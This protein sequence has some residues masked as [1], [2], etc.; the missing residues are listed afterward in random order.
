[1]RIFG[2]AKTEI[3][4]GMLEEKVKTLETFL[5]KLRAE[6]KEGLQRKAEA[7]LNTVIESAKVRA[8][9]EVL[10]LRALHAEIQNE[11]QKQLDEQDRQLQAFLD[12]WENRH[13]ELVSE[14]S[15]FFRKE[16]REHQK[17]LNELRREVEELKSELKALKEVIENARTE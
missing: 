5:L 10:R 3:R 14:I 7:E 11:F 9:A 15:R 17:E 2:K 16:R 1:M 8:E 12:R 4:L 13:R 6:M